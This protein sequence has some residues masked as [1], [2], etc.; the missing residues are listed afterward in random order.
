MLRII[1]PLTARRRDSFDA[2]RLPTLIGIAGAVLL[3]V[4]PAAVSQSAANLVKNPGAENSVGASCTSNTGFAAPAGWRVTGHFTALKND[5]SP[6]LGGVIGD[7]YFAGGDGGSSSA[8]Q[9][10]DLSANAAAID[11]RGTRAK[12]S[13]LLGGWQSQR[14]YA[15]V[16]VSFLDQAGKSLGSL[17]IGPVTP[18]DRNNQ[19]VLV[20]RSV[21]GPV[22]WRTR[23]AR[24]V[25]TAVYLDGAVYNDG[26]ADDV[27][28]TLQLGPPVPA[29]PAAT[30]P[31]P[32]PI[33]SVSNGCGGAGWDTVVRLQNYLGNTSRYADSNINPL[34]RT[35]PVN[36]K[37]ACDLHDA[38][39]AGAIVRDKL[40]GGRIVDF[41]TWSRERVD[42]KFLKDMRY[43]CKRQLPATALTARK[44][45]ES[46]GGN[47]S[48]GAK[49]RFNFVRCW[50][51]RFFDAAPG[52][53]G[54]QRT[55][56]RENDKVSSLSAYCR[57]A[58]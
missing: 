39:Y 16:R 52:R 54:T 5:C 21:S 17:K 23:R 2:L 11:G 25:L 7:Q 53:P 48:V 27:S 55:G 14:D 58:K 35:Y 3:A 40:N 28:L 45:C 12:L 10:V 9:D 49:S 43:L 8:S 44:N 36:F 46:T 38:G 33:E 19:T 32:V 24:I 41:R 4:T 37:D 51:N 22:P 42:E 47:A 29:P 13:G 6:P 56:P 1:G 18:A 31:K 57:F 50:G 20:P 30:T 26:Y 15:T 34:A